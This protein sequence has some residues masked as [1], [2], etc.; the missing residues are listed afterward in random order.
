MDKPQGK[1]SKS[2]YV[3]RIEMERRKKMKKR[4]KG[5]ENPALEA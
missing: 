1:E 2:K 3:K 4:E 5:K